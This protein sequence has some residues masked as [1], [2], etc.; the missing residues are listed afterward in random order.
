MPKWLKIGIALV[1]VLGAGG[2]AALQYAPP[3]YAGAPFI[4]VTE[5][6]ERLQRHPETLVL[7]VRTPREYHGELGHLDGAI[8]I[9]FRDIQ[10]ALNDGA[11][12]F[13]VPTSTPI[14]VH[15][16][17]DIRSAIAAKTLRS[18]GFKNI[19]VIDD[20]ITGWHAANLPVIVEEA[21]K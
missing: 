15:C 11:S 9:D 2:Y 10:T 5:A 4:S 14:L 7:D 17:T 6:Y 3:V 16:H 19:T 18:A 8:N 1:V 21:S 12:L 13:D 20:G